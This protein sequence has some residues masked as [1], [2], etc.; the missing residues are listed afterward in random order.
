MCQHFLNRDADTA[1][2]TVLANKIITEFA[3]AASISRIAERLKTDDELA[4][5]TFIRAFTN[6]SLWSDRFE[7]PSRFAVAERHAIT[8]GNTIRYQPNRRRKATAP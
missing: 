2:D 8:P 6:R 4:V 5:L 3:V 7:K 1:T